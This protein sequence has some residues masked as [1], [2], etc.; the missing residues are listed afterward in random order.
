M[1]RIGMHLY[2]NIHNYNDIVE[3]EETNIGKPLHSIHALDTY[4]T[5][6]EK[7]AKEL[8]SVE[9]EKITGPR[10]HMYIVEKNM[11]NAFWVLWK[12]STYAR[13]LTRYLNEN[14]AKYKTLSPFEIQIGACYGKFYEFEFKTT[15]ELTTIGY[16]ANFAA[17]L[18][19]IAVDN[20][21]CISQNIFEEL[22]NE[23]I[24]SQF[25]QK[26]NSKIYKYDQ[27]CYYEISLR[28]TNK[29]F[30]EDIYTRV[31]K[32]A[33]DTNLKDIRFSSARSLIN[34]EVLSLEN[35]KLV[36]GIPF[37]ADVRGFTSQFAEDD[38]NLE[39]MKA[40]TERVLSKMYET[41]TK[42]DGVHIQF[43]GDREVAIFHEY[44]NNR[45]CYTKS[46][47]SAMR[48]LD[49]VKNFGISI[50][51]GESLGKIFVTRIG[52]RGCK[53]NV[54]VGRVVNNAEEYEDLEASENEIVIASNIY[55]IL[56]ESNIKLAKL[57]NKRKDHYVSTVGYKKYLD[58]LK[59]EQLQNNNKNNN[60]NGAWLN[61]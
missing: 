52:A 9:I 41:V 44:G 27:N 8:G 47:I 17:K 38:S 45:D 42:N 51:I 10:L 55:Q 48:L 39:E 14:V 5:S 29:Y 56:Y 25:K 60:Y 1:K 46:V 40:T 58:S 7:Y 49:E 54:L 6:I 32:Y 16:A 21:L 43:Q 20:C 35:S 13:S 2:I 3:Y 22:T 12:I 15:L 57:F 34:S 28:S 53:D 24:K 33:N 23:S 61:E 36:I 37:F 4:F 59:C 31:L 26:T 50:G 11:D 30:N 19:S 18:Q